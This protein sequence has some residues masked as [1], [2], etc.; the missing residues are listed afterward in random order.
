MYLHAQIVGS[1]TSMKAI[2]KHLFYCHEVMQPYKMYVTTD[3]QLTIY[4]RLASMGRDSNFKS[5]PLLKLRLLK[6]LQD[7]KIG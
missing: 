2:K 4:P 1:V 3:S 5:F 6:L 7:D